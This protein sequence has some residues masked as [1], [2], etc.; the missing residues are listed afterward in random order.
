M[1]IQAYCDYYAQAPVAFDAIDFDPP[2]AIEAIEVTEGETTTIRQ[3]LSKRER[4]QLEAEFE[5]RRP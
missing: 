4:E 3:W 5:R 1:G 2:T